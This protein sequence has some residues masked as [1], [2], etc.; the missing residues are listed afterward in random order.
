M[1]TKEQQRALVELARQAVRDAT[2]G[3]AGTKPLPLPVDLPEASG[4]GYVSIPVPVDSWR[5]VPP[6]VGTAQ[7]C[8]RSMSFAF[9][10]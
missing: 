3:G 2:V 1:F 9:V 5:G 8:R 10:Q 7:M 6:A 4:A